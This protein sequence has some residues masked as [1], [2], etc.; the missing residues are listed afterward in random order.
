MIRT[1]ILFCFF[2]SAFTLHAQEYKNSAGLRFGK[3][4]GLTYKRFITPNAALETMLG[5]GGYDDGMQVYAN[6][7]WYKPIP[8]HIT[9][10]LH[11]YYGVGGHMGYIRPTRTVDYYEGDVIVSE[12]QQHTD[13]VIGVDGIIGVEY[14]IFT[15]PMTVGMELKPFFEYYALQYTRVR[16]WDFGFTVKY[17]F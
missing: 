10:N 1:A 4:E 5:F 3:T 13:Y 9:Q 14:R 2:L 6:Y 7:H 11:Y 16:F 12:T 8:A 15:V 17:I